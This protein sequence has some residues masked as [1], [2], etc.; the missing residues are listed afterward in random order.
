MAWVAVLDAGAGRKEQALRGHTRCGV[1]PL[2]ANPPEQ[3][4]RQTRELAVV[5]AW[6]G[7]REAA[8]RQLQ[9][10]VQTPAA[11]NPERS[12]TQSRVRTTRADP[13]SDKIVTVAAQPIK[14]SID[15]SDFALQR[16]RP[17]LILRRTRLQR[18]GDPKLS[19]ESR[20]FLFLDFKDCFGE[21]AETSTRRRVRSQ[22]VLLV[23]RLL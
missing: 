4:H 18:A 17:R 9:A 5:Y 1:W 6:T 7:E 13:R 23:T 15:R 3:R 22:F 8:I 21:G 10:I 20:T 16:V 19:L 12:E 14:K 11:L 2:P